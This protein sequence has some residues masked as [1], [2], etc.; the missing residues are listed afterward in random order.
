M[1]YGI[2]T[3]K[4]TF[5]IL[6][7]AKWQVYSILASGTNCAIFKISN[8]LTEIRKWIENNELKQKFQEI[9]VMC[10]KGT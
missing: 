10:M 5:R 6:E 2:N 1:I 3:Q 7:D 9:S 8:A 4:N